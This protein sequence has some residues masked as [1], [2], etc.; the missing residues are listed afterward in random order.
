V[1]LVL[2][3]SNPALPTTVNVL[4]TRH[5]ARIDEWMYWT[6]TALNYK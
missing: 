3:Q 4:P 5:R 1:T 2:I 6:L